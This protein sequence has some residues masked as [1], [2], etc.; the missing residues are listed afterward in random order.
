MQV[1]IPKFSAYTPE[2]FR[3]TI[4]WDRLSE[5]YRR[6][7]DVISH[8][9]PFRVND[10]VL[11]NLIDWEN[12]EE[13]PMFRL[14]FPQQNMLSEYQFSRISRSIKVG[15]K[16][17]RQEVHTVH[18]E[19][20]PHPAGQL[21]KNMKTHEGKLLE[22][23]QHKYRETALFFPSAGQTC[24]SY[25]SFCFRWPQFVGNAEWKIQV[26]ECEQL[27]SYLRSHPHITDVLITGG[28][29]M[30]MKT[31]PLRRYVEALLSVATIKTI[32]IGTK[33][34][35]YWPIRFLDQ[36]DD[37]ARLFE[38]I[39][40][41]GR[42]LAVMAHLNHWRELEPPAVRSAI[43]RVRGTGAVIRT[44]APLLRHINDDPE[45]W[46]RLWITSVRLGVIP[47][48]MFVER[49]TGP[50]R[51]F[52]V[53][54]VQACEIFSKAQQRVSGLSRTAR[55]PV[56]S[57]DIG[58]ISVDGVAAIGD[59]KALSLRFLQARDPS[60]VGQPFLAEYDEEALWIDDL[61]PYRSDTFFF[62]KTN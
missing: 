8:V 38:Q 59:S 45:V 61:K 50:S 1:D 49:D 40:H 54:L 5:D 60:Y 9:L 27:V 31:K 32:R 12:Y 26:R 57:T 47:Y 10:F 44:Q 28:D 34:L 62:E 33:A 53:P 24:H 15:G 19:L 6:T 25:C 16:D 18:C 29:P 4:Y 42:H 13:D 3:K 58:K 56:M 36:Y 23:V 7:F 17:L 21:T 43:E 41:S 48:Y 39:V 11:E 52:R 55:G 20:N 2:S 37:V 14:L 46:A 35:S 51:Y 30:I 22:G